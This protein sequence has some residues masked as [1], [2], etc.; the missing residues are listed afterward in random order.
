MISRIRGALTQIQ[1][2]TALVELN[3][4]SYEVML[5]SALAEA[6]QS[7]NPSED[8]ELYTFY[9]I[10]AGDKKSNHYPRLVGFTDR[11]EREFFSILL[12]VSGMGVKKTL[13]SLVLPIREIAYAIET[14]DTATLS[15]LPG[16]GGRLAEKII[17][18]LHGKVAKFAL[19][20]KEEPL[21]NR[22]V[23]RV[24]LF[25]EA[26]TVLTQLQY[27]KQEAEQMIKAALST[28]SKVD[29]VEE[30][31]TTIFRNEHHE[32]AGAV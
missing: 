18:E 32:K 23:T 22:T 5:P 20:R 10:E 21:A 19:S 4:L 1:E 29:S 24:P 8:I 12:Q 30:L 31:I 2:Q 25:D 27:S 26:V 11:V 6:F 9:Y 16:I 17:A 28:N 14:K 15:R 3:G 13:R 7:H